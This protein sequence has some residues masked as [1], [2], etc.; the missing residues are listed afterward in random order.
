MRI[1]I[2]TATMWLGGTEQYITRVTSRLRRQHGMDVDVCLID[3]SG[4]LLRPLE[5][6][7]ARVYGTSARARTRWSLPYSFAMTVGEIRQ[8]IRGGRY[9]IVHSYL[10]KAEAVATLAARLGGAPRII[11]TLRAVYPWRRPQGPLFYGVETVTNV[12]ADEVIANSQ[13]VLRDAARTERFLPRRRSVI[14]NGVDADEYQP[15]RPRGD[16]PLRLVSVGAL[17]DRKGH[18]FG[19][20]AMAVARAAGADARLTIV[21]G[22]SR[23]GMLRDLARSEGVEQLVTFAGAQEDPRP[24][25]TDADAF[26]LP[27]RQEGFSNA[28]LEAMA[29]ALPVIVTDVGGN[30][31][32][33]GDADGGIVVPP[34]DVGRLA[35]AIETLARRRA[36]LGAMGARNRERVR[37]LFSLDASASR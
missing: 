20:K 14:Y 13:L 32:A 10:F 19:I 34:C 1:L 9:D 17:A 27:S 7:G 23:E 3:R 28:L 30:R 31:E 33:V 24:F 11:I 8:I 4:P 2:V 18:E 29:T 37:E 22:G 6:T 35:G 21:G 5:A 16:G 12:L 36:D 25:L 15:A 26:M